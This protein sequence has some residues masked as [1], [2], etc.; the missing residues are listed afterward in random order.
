M[1][2]YRVKWEIDIEADNDLE[3]ARIALDIQRDSGSDATIF[4]VTKENSDKAQILDA[5]WDL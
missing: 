2:E 3:A 4:E 1:I 5:G